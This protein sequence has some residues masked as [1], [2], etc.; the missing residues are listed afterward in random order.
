MIYLIRVDHDNHVD[1]ERERE[2]IAQSLGKADHQ[3]L[4]ESDPVRML[5]W[6]KDVYEQDGLDDT[7]PQEK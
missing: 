2:R 5:D 3:V 4:A 7:D 6:M 1:I